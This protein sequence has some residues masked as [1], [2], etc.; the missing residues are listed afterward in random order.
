MGILE[1][2]RRRTEQVSMPSSV[3]LP[4]W[5]IGRKTSEEVVEKLWINLERGFTINT[6]LGW[7]S[8]EMDLDSK[9]KTIAVVTKYH[10][11][12]YR[13]D[14]MNAPSSSC[15]RVCEY[16]SLKS[17]FGKPISPFGERYIFFRHYE[18]VTRS[19]YQDDSLD[20]HIKNSPFNYVNYNHI[21]GGWFFSCGEDSAQ[22]LLNFFN[23]LKNAEVDENATLRLF[24]KEEERAVSNYRGT[25]ITASWPTITVDFR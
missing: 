21:L 7:P 23:C 4:T 9:R 19:S 14:E 3:R 10:D 25:E 22:E 6:F 2:F 16:K 11:K 18:D 24:R 17:L 8:E 15:L 20:F 1:I 13:I 12:Y 5:E